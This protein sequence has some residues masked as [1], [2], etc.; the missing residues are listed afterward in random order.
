M[1]CNLRHNL[2]NMRQNEHL[3][4]RAAAVTGL[5]AL[6]RSYGVDAARLLREAGL[7]GSIET[8]PDR[9]IPVEAVNRVFELAAMRTGRD[10]FG[11]RLCELRGFS[12][13]GP[14]GLIARDEPTVG[15]A[16]AAIEAYLPLHNDALVITRERYGDL[17]LLRTAILAQGP[18]AQARDIAVAMQH[19]IIRQLAG[20]NW[21]AE[22]VCLT[23]PQPTDPVRFRQVLGPRLRFAAEFDGIVVSAA[24][25]DRPNPMAD[26][27]FRPYASR[28]AD[29]ADPGRKEPMAQRVRRV[30]SVLLASRRCTA[31]Q[32]AA[33]LGLSRRTLTRALEAEGTRFLAV[34]DQVR[35]EVAQRHLAGGA[36]SLGEIADL[37]G[38]SSPAAF[39]IWFRRCHAISPGQWRL[40]QVKA[41]GGKTGNGTLHDPRT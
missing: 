9:R 15:A 8:Q 39:S 5:S 37:L 4:V 18:A 11:L 33:Q 28:L 6:C 13:L 41:R 14:I 29:L 32:V 38:F 20:S 3:T 25:L 34:L 24:L 26:P 1:L 23:R 17:V 31:G 27:A 35:S 2:I 10:D 7:P 30:L 12:N 19:R 21:Q 36:R 22:E 40:R 16:L